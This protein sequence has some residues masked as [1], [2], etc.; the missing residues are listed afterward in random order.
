MLHILN[1]SIHSSVVN[2]KS[3][4]DN[5]ITFVSNIKKFSLIFSILCL[6]GVYMGCENTPSQCVEMCGDK[7]CWV[8]FNDYCVE[9]VGEEI[10]FGQYPQSGTEPEPIIW[11]VRNMIFQGEVYDYLEDG[12]MYLYL[13]SEYVL[14]AKP[15]NDMT[16]DG[17]TWK[18]SS[19]RTWL[20]HDFMDTAFSGNEKK[21]IE[22]TYFL[23]YEQ[24]IGPENEIADYGAEV[25]AQV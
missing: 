16:A 6:G 21:Y 20:N 14:D 3:H 19:I 7:C 22:K 2:G 23:N 24:Y 15:Y 4:T 13:V 25:V 5:H 12:Y 1:P 18:D 8:V 11:N 17:F 10:A 9:N